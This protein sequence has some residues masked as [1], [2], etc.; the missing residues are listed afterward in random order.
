[1]LVA[2]QV[3]L[4]LV[5]LT[6]AGLLL[7]SFAA[8][9]T[10]DLGYNPK[11]VLTHFL[12]LPPSADGSRSAGA[13]LFSRIREHIRS[14][15]GVREVATASAIP[16]FGVQINMDVHPEGEPE[17]RHEQQARAPQSATTISVRWRSRCEAAGVSRALTGTARRAWRW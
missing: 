6:G 5:L 2:A 17:R 11:Q 8:I 4:S 14:I 3:A 16:M 15:P 10:A 9:R 1:M 12:A 7:R 13:M